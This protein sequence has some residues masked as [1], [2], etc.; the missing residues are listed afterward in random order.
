MPILDE[1]PRELNGAPAQ[2][3]AIIVTGFLSFLEENLKKRPGRRTGLSAAS[4]ARTV[5]LTKAVKGSDDETLPQEV[6]L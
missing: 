6:T 5:R 1:V 3:E 2:D 4:L